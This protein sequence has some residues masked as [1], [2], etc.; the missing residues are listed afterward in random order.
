MRD[1]Y[2]KAYRTIIWLGSDAELME[3]LHST[4]EQ[5]YSY[6][7]EALTR[8]I[9]AGRKPPAMK[10]ETARTTFELHA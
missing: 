8:E 7:P 2:A 1:I 6:F 5:A 10:D 9:D 4:V 3:N